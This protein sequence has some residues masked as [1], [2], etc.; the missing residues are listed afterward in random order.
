MKSKILILFASALIISSCG[1]PSGK[2]VKS[3]EAKK[4]KTEVS[5]IEYLANTS[6]SNINWLGTKSTGE[7][8]GDIKIKSGKL[9]MNDD[10]L[11]GGEFIIDMNTISNEDLEDATY[12]QKLVGHLKSADFFDVEKFPIAS[13]KITEAKILENAEMIDGIT[14]NYNITG[15]LTLKGI[16]KS[17]TFEAVVDLNDKGVSAF[18]PQFVIDRS[19]WDVRYGSRKFFDDLKDKFIYD[20]MGIDISLNAEK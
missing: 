5:G 6:T 12:N 2:K 4:E 9:V 8:F 1:G 13:F 19:E 20:E 14:P 18:A 10:V 7:H 17:I 16:T 11:V 3:E 15:N